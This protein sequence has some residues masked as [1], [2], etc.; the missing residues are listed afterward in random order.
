MKKF[1]SKIFPLVGTLIFPY[2]FVLALENC[3]QYEELGRN[4]CQGRMS[5]FLTELDEQS[6]AFQR[7]EDL[8]NKQSTGWCLPVSC[9]CDCSSTT[10]LLQVFCPNLTKVNENVYFRP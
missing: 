7:K 2:V 10:S 9:A 8:K 6:L 4:A 3:F 1:A 5:P